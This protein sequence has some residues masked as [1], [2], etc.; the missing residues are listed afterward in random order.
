MG[1]EEKVK[2]YFQEEL[3][4]CMHIREVKEFP[5]TLHVVEDDIP[6]IARWSYNE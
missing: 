1:T 4:K 5:A 3:A 6:E 2:E